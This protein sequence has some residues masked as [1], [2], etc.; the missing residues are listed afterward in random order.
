MNM[1]GKYDL[2]SLNVSKRC[3]VPRIE[4][5]FITDFSLILDYE[6]GIRE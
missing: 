6:N 2:G 3:M 5:E 4:L 1:N